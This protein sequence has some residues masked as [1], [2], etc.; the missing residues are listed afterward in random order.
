[1]LDV[2]TRTLHTTIPPNSV[3]FKEVQIIRSDAVPRADY[4][5]VNIHW[6]LA[7]DNPEHTT[8]TAPRIELSGT[9]PIPVEGHLACHET[10]TTLLVDG[11]LD[12]WE[13]LPYAWKPASVPRKK[14]ERWDGAKDSSFRFATRYDS[15]YAYIGIRVVDDVLVTHPEKNT[16]EQDCLEVRFDAR[17]EQIRSLGRGKQEG[18]DFLILSMVPGASPDKPHLHKPESLPAGT[19][20]AMERVQDGYTAEIAIP[21]AYLTEK[22]KQPWNSFRLNV[23]VDD[24]DVPES[25]TFLFHSWRPDWRSPENYEGSGTFYKL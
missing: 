8:G 22:Q 5:P 7:F 2:S 16:W 4:P 1:V 11:K 24:Y 10:T 6:Q 3:S 15:Y 17:P 21:A 14:G 19:K 23:A 20:V 12:D 9:T 13:A 25:P 18:T